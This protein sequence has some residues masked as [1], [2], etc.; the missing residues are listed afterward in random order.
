MNKRLLRPHQRIESDINIEYENVYQLFKAKVCQNP[1]KKF[2]FSP[3]EKEDVF[4]YGDFHEKFLTVARYLRSKGL[5][6]GDRIN[7]LM[8]NSPEFVLLYFS[9]LTLGITLVSINP[10]FSPEEI[11][12]II[13]NC[14]SKAVFYDTALQHKLEKLKGKIGVGVLL[15]KL[16]RLPDFEPIIRASVLKTDKLEIP[17]VELTDEAAVLYTS[18]TTGDP[19]GVVLTHLNLLAD[20]K[21]ISE[22]FHFNTDTRALCILP[23]FHNNGQVVTLLALL[24][25]GGSTVIVK[26]KAS[27]MAFWTLVKK[28]DVNWTS[29]MPSIISILLSISVDRKDSTMQGI[30]CGG[31]VLT[32]SV[33]NDFENRFKVPVFEG[34]GLTETTSFACFNDYP[35]EKRKKGS[36]GIPLP[37]TEMAI[38]DKDGKELGPNAVGEIC[39]KGLNVANEYFNMPEQNRESFKNSWFHSGDFG[40]KDE[41]GYYYFRTREDNLI[42][43]G[44]ENI[45]PAELENVLFKHHGVAECAVIGVPDKLLGEEICAF[46]KLKKG[47]DSS[48]EELK[49]FCQGKI[50]LFKQA[51]R[52]IIVDKT[53]L[54]EIPKGPTKKVLYTVLR[55]HYEKKFG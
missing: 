52:I 55:R 6:K 15:E 38:I 5:K 1:D 21:A 47:A 30:I 22:W 40:Y 53:D 41:E 12:Y 11:L 49:K 44:G 51:K 8:Q 39:I 31:Q 37:I 19:K 28:Y 48:E 3:G 10:D 24:Y 27:L 16:S 25:S 32:E 29:V 9:S 17:L 23:L 36:V 33:Q 26:G 45:Y 13:Q 7:L 18:G 2:L 43:K 34:Y 54:Y 14:K 42:I 46:V 50:A 4:S 35:S 20:A